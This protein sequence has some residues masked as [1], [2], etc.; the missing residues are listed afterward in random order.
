MELL[1][2]MTIL[3]VLI[4]L[5]GNLIMTNETSEESAKA[6][7]EPMKYLLPS[8]QLAIGYIDEVPP[9]A[10]LPNVG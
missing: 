3:L 5:V 1:L 9:K 7:H 8:I 10:R 6:T 4:V 2:T